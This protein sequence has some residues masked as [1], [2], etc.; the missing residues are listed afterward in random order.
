MRERTLPGIGEQRL[1]LPDPDLSGQRIERESGNRTRD[2]QPHGRGA[3]VGERE[4]REL[5]GAR[6]PDQPAQAVHRELTRVLR[7]IVRER[8]FRERRPLFV[9]VPEPTLAQQP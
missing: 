9:E 6:H 1:L 2:P 5:I 7:Q 4:L 3:R 8:E